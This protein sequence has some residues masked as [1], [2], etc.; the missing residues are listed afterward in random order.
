MVCG[1]IFTSCGRT[2]LD[3]RS[4]VNCGARAYPISQT[5]K[6]LF[7]YIFTDCA[8]TTQRLLVQLPHPFLRGTSLYQPW[9]K[10]FNPNR[11]LGVYI[12]TWISLTRLPLEYTK[13][14]ESIASVVG[15]VLWEDAFGDRNVQSKI[16]YGHGLNAGVGL[17]SPHLQPSR[18]KCYHLD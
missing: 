3:F 4:Q 17:C 1:R 15:K 14:A 11:L 16:L 2:Q 10:A 9:M 6:K 7:F 18:W 13:F 5:C 12:P 8:A